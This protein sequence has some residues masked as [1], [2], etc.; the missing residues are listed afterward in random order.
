VRF[1][2]HSVVS[3]AFRDRSRSRKH[4]RFSP[5]PRPAGARNMQDFEKI[6]GRDEG[7]EKYISKCSCRLSALGYVTYIVYW[8]KWQHKCW[9]EDKEIKTQINY[10]YG[11]IVTQKTMKMTQLLNAKQHCQLRLWTRRHR[12]IIIN[13]IWYEKVII[14]RSFRYLRNVW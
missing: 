9:N 5:Y 12:H 4:F 8:I 10:K 14:S 13:S 6:E 2:R 3:L 1:L 11:S 7:I